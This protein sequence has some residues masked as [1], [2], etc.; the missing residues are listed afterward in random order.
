MAL[1]DAK[2]AAEAASR[3][4]SQFLASMSHELRTPLNSVIGFSKV[5]LNQADG[6]LTDTQALYVRTMHENSTHLLRLIDELLDLARIEAGK[7]ELEREEVQLAALVHECVQAS[8]P[9][10]ADKRV[11]LDAEVEGTIAPVFADRTKLKQVLLNL[12]GNAIKFTTVGRIVVTVRATPEAAQVSVSD[13]GRGIP[14]GDLP[15]IFDPFRQVPSSGRASSGVGLGLAICKTFVGLHDGRIW[16][17][18]R[19]WQGSTFHFTVPYDRAE[20]GGPS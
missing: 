5:L 4:K 15:A 12:L 2:D 14:A 1:R 10:L 7:T 13:T 6:G 19:E 3:A 11:F 8:R 18:S 9:L 17:E 20:R 16:V